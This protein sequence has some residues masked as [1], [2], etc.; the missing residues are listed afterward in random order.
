MPMPTNYGLAMSRRLR[1]TP[2]TS[3]LIRDGVK[4]FTAYN[5]MLLPTEFDGLESEYWHLCEAVQ[6]WDVS[7]ER[8]VS[9]HGPDASRLVQWM[10]PRDISEVKDDRCVYLP[11]VD[12]NGRLVN[13]PIGIRIADDH[14]WLS[15]ADSDVLLWARGL[16]RG[17]NLDVE[18][19]EPDVWPLAVQ[20]PHAQTL[21]QRVFGER[22]KDIKFFRYARLTYQDHEFIVARS[23]WSKQGGFEIYVDNIVKGQALYDELFQQGADLNVRPGYPN[24]IER[25]ESTL[26][27]FGGD[28]D[29]RHSPIEAGLGAFLD[30]DKNIDSLSIAALRAERDAGAKRRLRGLVVDAPEG[31]KALAADPFVVHEPLAHADVTADYSIHLNQELGSY[32]GAQVYSPRYRQQLG[33]AMLEEPLAS[34]PACEVLLKSGKSTQA[35]IVDLPFDFAALGLQA[36]LPPRN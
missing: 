20:G 13:D 23:G 4:S 18:V 6:V 11:L 32:L 12:E 31:A 17:A 28:M 24:L 27:S 21:M 25:V 34:E 19:I 8:Q 35:S 1:A 7:A 22:V 29:I 2:F 16:A 10:T 14:W 15:I 9:I 5:H 33:L 30:L 26:L 3:R 36:Y